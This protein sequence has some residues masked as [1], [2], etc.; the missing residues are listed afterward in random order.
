MLGKLMKHEFKATGRLVPLVFMA[1]A[2]F[3]L[4]TFLTRQTGWNAASGISLFFF[5]IAGAAAVIITYVV[6]ITRFYKSMYANE[7]YLSLTLP[8]EGWK[9]IFTKVLTSFIWIT[10]SYAVMI[11]TI[12]LTVVFAIKGNSGVWAEFKEQLFMVFGIREKDFWRIIL[13]SSV[14]ALIQTLAGI[15]QIYFAIT[16]ANTGSFQKNAVAFSFVFYLAISFIVQMIG[17]GLILF[18]PLSFYFGSDGAKIVF[19]P[20]I[21][22]MNQQVVDKI[23][24]SSTL[25]DLAC[26]GGLYAGILKLL[27]RR[28]SVR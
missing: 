9:L 5:I 3:A 11:A 24:L 10:L 18:V 1:W 28:V 2:I 16:L 14:A 8:V 12:I 22:S 6:V 23:G 27:Q 17:M 4:S 26:I 13:Y 21:S 15:M 25:L 7:G 20:M 19:E